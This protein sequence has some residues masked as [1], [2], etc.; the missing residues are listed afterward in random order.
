MRIV[1]SA[2][3]LAVID[4]LKA[5]TDPPAV[6][7]VPPVP[8]ALPIPTTA[9]PTETDEVLVVTVWRPDAPFSWMTATSSV[10]S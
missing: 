9:S 8:P 2:A 7:G 5:V 4:W 1:P 3:S 6:A 10:R